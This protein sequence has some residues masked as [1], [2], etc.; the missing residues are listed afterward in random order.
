[1][2]KLPYL[3]ASN[4]T[5][6]NLRELVF[7]IDGLNVPD[8]NLSA[9]KDEI[10][11]ENNSD[12]KFFKRITIQDSIN[13]IISLNNHCIWISRKSALP[14]GASLSLTNIVWASGL[15]TWKSLSK[16]GIWVNGC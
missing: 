12:Y 9:K 15:K 14:K 8:S 1:M 11:P 7:F 13:K 5:R 3:K 2:K 4:S 6:S 16:R 10:F